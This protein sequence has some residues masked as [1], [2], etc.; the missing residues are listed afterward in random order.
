MPRGGSA[1]RKPLGDAIAAA[2]KAFESK[3][4]S[5]A[6]AQARRAIEEDPG[7]VPGL[8]YAAAALVELGRL[9]DA[10]EAY[11]RALATAPNDPDVIFGMADLLISRL[12][13]EREIIERGL[14]LCQRGV[15]RA[16]KKGDSE[17]VGEFALLEAIALNHLGLPKDALVR[18]EEA[19][20]RFPRDPDVLLERGIALFELCRFAAAGKAFRQVVEKH[21]D[22]AW[23]HHYLGL[24]SER[25]GDAAAARRHLA[26][27]QRIA[28]DDFPRPVDFTAEDFDRSVE[29]ALAELPE[30]VRQYLTNVAITVEDLPATED[31]TAGDAP[32][33]PSILGVFRG[34]SLNEQR[35]FH[36]YVGTADPWNYQPSSIVLFQRNLQR[37]A[38]SREELI[39]QIGITLIHEVGH[40]LGLDEEE[41]RERGLE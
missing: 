10:K 26:R 39:E 28:P 8:H 6:L 24:V 1:R 4:P 32:L 37:F 13:D 40:F 3:N 22:D 9:D 30:R 5:E 35:R 38:R 7:S 20:E 21:P 34:Q 18:I 14:E 25:G 16:R 27:A 33:S 15:R 29:E 19:S 36:D 11:E 12:G 2:E 17:L 23:A 41:L 31:L